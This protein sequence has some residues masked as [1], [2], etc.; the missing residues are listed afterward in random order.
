ML[1]LKNLLPLLNHAEGKDYYRIENRNQS[2]VL[3]KNPCNI[4]RFSI[5]VSS[6]ERSISC[7]LLSLACNYFGTYGVHGTSIV[8]RMCGKGW[9]KCPFG[10]VCRTK[11][12]FFEFSRA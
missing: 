8:S 6:S 10:E 11:E 5:S 7:Y 2:V 1:R 9:I 3:P 12:D 4:V